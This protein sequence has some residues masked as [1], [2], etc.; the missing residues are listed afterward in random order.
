MHHHTWLIWQA[1]MRRIKAS[2]G[3]ASPYL[4][5]YPTHTKKRLVGWLKW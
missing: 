5:K 2:L 1:E 3:K 4:K